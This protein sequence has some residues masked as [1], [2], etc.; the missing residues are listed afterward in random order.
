MGVCYKDVLFK[1]CTRVYKKTLYF[2]Y[3]NDSF[4]IHE[5]EKDMVLLET[6]PRSYDLI[7]LGFKV[8]II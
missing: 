7:S 3:H 5:E 4:L 1:D 8:E 6:G 2:K